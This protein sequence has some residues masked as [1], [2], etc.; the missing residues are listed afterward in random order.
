M[1]AVRHAAALLALLLSATTSV[2]GHTSVPSDWMATLSKAKQF[3]F[4]SRHKDAIAL[5][6]PVVNAYPQ[7]DDAHG[8]LGIAYEAMGRELAAGG[9]THRAGAARTI[10]PIT[11][12]RPERNS[13]RSSVNEGARS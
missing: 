10:R 11:P 1:R 7:F 12:H 3:T 2:V 13:D 5:L 9:D 4:D 6:E 8:W